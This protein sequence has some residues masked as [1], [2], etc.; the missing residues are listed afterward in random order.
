MVNPTT[1]TAD[2]GPAIAAVMEASVGQHRTVMPASASAVYPATAAWD[3]GPRAIVGSRP[4]L[5]SRQS[6]ASSI[7]G[8][9]TTRYLELSCASSVVAPL[10]AAA[11]W[12]ADSDVKVTSAQK[13]K[14]LEVKRIGY[15][16]DMP[17]YNKR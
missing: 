13:Q 5:A 11:A 10:P 17:R 2:V 7:H 6:V 3:P 14:E 16:D 15:R 12:A 4:R 1:S 9:F 8:S